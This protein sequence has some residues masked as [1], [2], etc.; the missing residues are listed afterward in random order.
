MTVSSLAVFS[1]IAFV[2]LDI[3]LKNS[4]GSQC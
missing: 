3:A 1:E 4:I 2:Q